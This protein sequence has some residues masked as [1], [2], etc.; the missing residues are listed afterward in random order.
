[1]G[2]PWWFSDSMLPLRLLASTAGDMGLIP[3]QRSNMM[4]GMAKKKIY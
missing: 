4:H 1:M 3:D 2:L